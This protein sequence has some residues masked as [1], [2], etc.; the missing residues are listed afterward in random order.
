MSFNLK[1]NKK[2]QTAQAKE[3]LKQQKMGI[4]MRLAYVY[5]ALYLSSKYVCLRECKNE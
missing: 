3:K 2:N 5:T 4:L 1:Q